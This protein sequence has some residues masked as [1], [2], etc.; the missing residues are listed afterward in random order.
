MDRN[1]DSRKGFGKGLVEIDFS[2][3]L[4]N[5]SA[6]LLSSLRGVDATVVES[7]TR[8]GAGDIT[9]LLKRSVQAR[10]VVTKTVEL[11]DLNSSD[12]GAYA[13]SGV[14]QNEGSTTVGMSFKV[15]ARVIAGTKT[16]FTGRRVHVKLVLK[17]STVGV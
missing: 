10:Y 13:T 7:F 11:E 14:T 15:Y 9:V 5:T 2:F 17:N 12:D 1:L 3:A 8:N 4:N 6:P 16:D